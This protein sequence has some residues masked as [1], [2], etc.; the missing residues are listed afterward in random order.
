MEV[1]L[2]RRTETV[3]EKGI[4]YGQSDVGIRKPYNAV[5]ESI[6]R[7]LPQDA[8]LYSSPLQ[9]C[10]ILAKHIRENSKIDSI[11][12]DSLQKRLVIQ[13]DSILKP[14]INTSTSDENKPVIESK[15]LKW[16]YLKFVFGIIFLL[17][18]IISFF[19]EWFFNKWLAYRTRRRNLNSS[20]IIETRKTVIDWYDYKN[21][22]TTFYEEIYFYQIGKLKSQTI[23][24][25]QEY[26]TGGRTLL[27]R[28][29]G[30]QP[31]SWPQFPVWSVAH[32]WGRQF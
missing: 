25:S 18:L 7:E 15:T 17:T 30:R 4:C 12:E 26:Q 28:G 22:L 10:V 32:G 1:Y 19:Y 8:V 13:F 27:F 23:Q 3:C 31:A 5:F 6:L 2:I 24:K 9:R 20:V 16:N 14:R 21:E 11:I 29:L